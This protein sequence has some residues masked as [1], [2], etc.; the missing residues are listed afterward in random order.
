MGYPRLWVTR[1]RGDCDPEWVYHPTLSGGSV[2]QFDCGEFLNRWQVGHS[3]HDEPDPGSFRV[4]RSVLDCF[5][6]A[7]RQLDLAGCLDGFVAEDEGY[8]LDRKSTRLNSS[9]LGIS[10]A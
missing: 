3:L 10:Y 4:A 9:H 6:D 2:R 1:H 5:G 7:L 8:A